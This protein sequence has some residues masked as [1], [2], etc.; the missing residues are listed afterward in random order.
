MQQTKEVHIFRGNAKKFYMKFGYYE[1]YLMLYIKME[2]EILQS[3][4]VH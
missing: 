2:Y 3:K 4:Q 1:K